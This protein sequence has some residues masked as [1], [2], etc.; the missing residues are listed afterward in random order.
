MKHIT[1]IL[2]I[3]T[4]LLATSCA[5]QSQYNNLSGK[6][7]G[8]IT[9]RGKSTLVELS[10]RDQ[11]DSIEGRFTILSMTGKDMDKGMAFDIV[12]IER[13]GNKLKFI[14]P[15]TGKVDDDAIAFELLAQG[16]RLTGHGN[17]LRKGSKNIPI[18]FAKHE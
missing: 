11:Q 16:N 6:W 7:R 5:N 17:E 15:I 12:R 3:S 18:I 4:V 8:T 9:E 13:S 1:R 14:V 2:I 10:L